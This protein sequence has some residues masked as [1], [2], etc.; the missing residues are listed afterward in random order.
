M[1]SSRVGQLHYSYRLPLVP[2]ERLALST[3]RVKA[4]YAIQLRHG[5]LWC[6]APRTMS[7]VLSIA[8]EGFPAVAGFVD[9]PISVV[10]HLLPSLSFVTFFTKQLANFQFLPETHTRT[11]VPGESLILELTNTM[12][13][14]KILLNA[15]TST[16]TAKD[17]VSDS[18]PLIVTTQ[19]INSHVLVV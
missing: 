16:H 10:R 5:G 6:Q 12:I 14:L 2:P 18:D 9:Y 4:G 11:G 1:A 13:D 15:T 17:R 7:K 8:L 19:H 3:Y